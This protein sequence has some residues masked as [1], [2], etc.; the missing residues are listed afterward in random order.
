MHSG[1]YLK[2]VLF[3]FLN[4]GP[5]IIK[6]FALYFPSHNACIF[7]S[8]IIIFRVSVY[9]EGQIFI[10]SGMTFFPGFFIRGGFLCLNIAIKL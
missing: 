5:Q 2:W 7:Y 1:G 4:K 10:M 9:A 3:S 8:T 6:H